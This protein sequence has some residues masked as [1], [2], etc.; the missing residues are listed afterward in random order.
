MSSDSTIS[1][2]IIRKHS[3]SSFK[4]EAALSPSDDTALVSRLSLQQEVHKCY[5][6]LYNL[7]LK[8]FMRIVVSR[9]LHLFV[10]DFG[11]K[12]NGKFNSQF[13]DILVQVSIR[14]AL[15]LVYD[16]ITRNVRRKKLAS[17]NNLLL[18]Q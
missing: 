8:G 7:F 11:T 13:S 5:I 14:S 3:Q 15:L 16:H 17:D 1:T 6:F 12:T 9:I 4:D 2:I 18:S 10:I